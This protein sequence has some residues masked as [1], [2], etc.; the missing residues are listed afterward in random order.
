MENVSMQ[1]FEQRIPLFF[2]SQEA[3]VT[4][5]VSGQMHASNSSNFEYS[6]LVIT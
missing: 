2:S 3:G 5:N 1:T 6:G 4:Y